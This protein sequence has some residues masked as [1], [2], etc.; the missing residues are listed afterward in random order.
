MIFRWRLT[1]LELVVNINRINAKYGGIRYMKDGNV[2]PGSHGLLPIW[3]QN[4]YT[5]K[6]NEIRLNGL[7][8]GAEGKVSLLED[9]AMDL[10]LRIFSRE[11]SFQTLLSMVPAIYLKDFETLKTS[12]NLKLE[13]NVKGI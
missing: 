9:G 10:D 6:K 1:D 3:L 8:L 13:G 4:K 2:W 11:T 7:V 12:G 5:L